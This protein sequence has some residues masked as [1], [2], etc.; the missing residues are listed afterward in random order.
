[1]KAVPWQ[2][3]LTDL[4][5]ND[6]KQEEPKDIFVSRDTPARLLVKN[7]D[8]QGDHCPCSCLAKMAL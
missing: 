5:T 3:E 4:H 1:M 7:R 8:A 2:V 6:V